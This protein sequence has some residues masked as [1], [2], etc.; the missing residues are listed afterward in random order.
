MKQ[1]KSRVIRILIASI[2]A[3]IFIGLVG[4]AFRYLL[5]AADSQRNRE[6]AKLWGGL[7][8]RDEMEVQLIYRNRFRGT[9]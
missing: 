3:G 6:H 4:G 5:I 7:S 9:N 8:W 2:L 1:L